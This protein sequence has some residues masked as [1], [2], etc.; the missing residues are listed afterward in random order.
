MFF[1][2]K[3]LKKFL[4][5]KKFKKIFILT[6]IKSYNL[7]GAKKIF[8]K[9]LENKTTKFYFKT[10]PYPEINEL[11]KITFSLNKFLPDLVIA[12]GGGSVLDYAKIANVSNINPNLKE[13]I[14][15][16]NYPIKKRLSKLVAIPTTAGSGAEVTSSAVIYINKIKY[17]IENDLIKPNYFFLMPELVMK[18]PNKIKSSSGF[19]AIAQAVESMISKKSN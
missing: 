14:L 5:D 2:K 8:D 10:S 1:I 13:Q 11:K 12:I 9:L 19:D 16:Y 15:N 4:S 6:G 3:D 17:S 7:S 18:N